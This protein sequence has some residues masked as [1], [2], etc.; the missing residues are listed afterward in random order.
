MRKRCSLSRMIETK[1]PDAELD[2]QRM[3]SGAAM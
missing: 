1:M 3:K 2:D